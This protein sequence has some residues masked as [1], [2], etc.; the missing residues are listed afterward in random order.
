MWTALPKVRGLTP[1]YLLLLPFKSL[2]GVVLGMITRLYALG[3]QFLGTVVTMMI[4][5]NTP[6]AISLKNTPEG[7][8]TNVLTFAGLIVLFLF[9]FHHQVF[10][11]IADTYRALPPVRLSIRRR[12]WCR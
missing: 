1:D 11:A 2:I 3:L 10:I 12:R 7:Q 5:L 6:P 9:D 8:I 4:G